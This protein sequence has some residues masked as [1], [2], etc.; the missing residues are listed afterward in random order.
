MKLV[1]D[2]ETNGLL[3]ELDR[4]HC[5]CMRDLD[6]GKDYSHHDHLDKWFPIERGL[7]LLEK[8]DML[9]GHNI[10]QFDI[11]AIQKVYP[12]WKP[13][14]IVRDTL[15]MSRLQFPDLKERDFS[16]ARRNE[17][18]PKQLI[19]SHSLKAWGH[20]ILNYKDDYDGGWDHWSQKMQRYCEQD[21]EV[22]ASL[23]DKLMSKKPSQESIELEHR[24]AQ[25]IWRQ[26]Q[27]GFAFDADG[28]RKL[29]ADLL[30]RRVELGE[31]LSDHFPPWIVRTPFTPKRDNKTK[32]YVKGVTIHKEREVEFNPNSRDHIALKLREKY[33]WKPKEFTPEGKPKID[34]T[35]LEKLPYPEAKLLAENF[36]LT[37]RLGQIGE[38]RNS[39][40][41]LERDGRIHGRVNTNGAV[42]GRMTH[43]HP[44]MAQVPS[45]RALWGTE[46]RSLF[47]ADKGYVLLGCDADG[48]ELRCL[49]GYMALFDGGKY[50]TTVLEG[51]KEAGTDMH[52]LN[53]AVLQ[54]SRDE[55]KTWFYAF[56]Y[57]A[58][59]A[60]LGAILGRSAQAGA[61]SKTAFLK[62]LPALGRL[63]SSVQ[64]KAQR[65]GYIK[66]LDGRHIPVRSSHAALNT[67]LQ[68]AGAVFMKK[69]LVLLDDSLHVKGLVPG[70][71]YEFVA[72]VHD[73]FQIQVKEEHAQEVGESAVAAI[74]G[75]G[76]AYGFK[77][78]LDAQYSTGRTW[79]DTH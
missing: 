36:L 72:N 60:K 50:V 26:E 27:Y 7:E 47:I 44:N 42:T 76:L 57:G 20:R 65:Q 67:L 39:W 11:P 24:V 40:I 59:S 56:I 77:C 70:V 53:A 54:C 35:V 45:T 52:S 15:V 33:G 69:A 9:I 16:Y 46:C 71:D 55:A 21:V 49:A 1:F 14:G 17:D 43:S 29:Y 4:L 74:R 78:P 73:E 3:P 66:G 38:G 22:T 6:T 79:A 10:I 64:A 75:A 8:A 62:S 5:L 32:G 51:D 68:G 48:L 25:I 2:I 41:K 31:R 58:G 23:W 13:R 61:K 18:F 12:R 30:S 34:E 63:V 19:G 37:K 28:A